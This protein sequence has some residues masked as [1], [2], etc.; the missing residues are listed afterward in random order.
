MR[1]GVASS[2]QKDVSFREALKDPDTRAEYIRRKFPLLRTVLPNVL[3]SREDLQVL[4]WW[5]EAFVTAI[6]QSTK[7]MPY[8]MRYIARETLVF[9]RVSFILHEGHLVLIKF[10]Q[11]KFPSAPEEAYA[12][13]I[14]R[15][16]YYRY[17]NP[18]I[19]CVSTARFY[20]GPAD[21]LNY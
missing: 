9:L 19:M 20:F 17:I 10:H 4:Q 21:H 12:A 5:T 6:T 1:S 7:K 18:A 8:G 16:V 11:D 13:C 14:G 3:L 15:L 2:K